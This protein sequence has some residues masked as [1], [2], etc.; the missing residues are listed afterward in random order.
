M[1]ND[2][3][4]SVERFLRLT[5]DRL[6]RYAAVCTERF[7]REGPE[8]FCR[9]L[10][11]CLSD[12]DSEHTVYAVEMGMH[13]M[14]SL[15]LDNTIRLLQHSNSDVC[16]AAFRAIDTLPPRL[17]TNAAIDQIKATP[18]VDLFAT[19]FATGRPARSGTNEVFLRK[20]YE[21]LGIREPEH[22]HARY[23]PKK[24]RHNP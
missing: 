9:Q 18:V 3:A 23:E 17:I 24:D 13:L 22:K 14:P 1:M 19:S 6:A 5:G 8:A 20:I 2:S 4:F 16:C 10:H 7:A 11:A 21:R 12:M 15:F